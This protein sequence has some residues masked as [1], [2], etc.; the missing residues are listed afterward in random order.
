MSLEERAGEEKKVAQSDTISRFHRFF[1]AIAVD[2]DSHL[3]KEWVEIG[4]LIYLRFPCSDRQYRLRCYGPVKNDSDCMDLVH[5][6][7][8]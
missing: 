7:S 4:G 2:T 3:H 6:L 1:G 8:Q 5:F